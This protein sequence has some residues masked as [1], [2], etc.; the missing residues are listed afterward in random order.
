[1]A[2]EFKKSGI[3]VSDLG[4]V[5]LQHF[6]VDNILKPGAQKALLTQLADTVSMGG[7]SLTI[8]EVVRDQ[9]QVSQD[10]GELD[11]YPEAS[12]ELSAKEILAKDFGK[13]IKVT[14]EAQNVQHSALDVLSYAKDELVEELARDLEERCAAA[15][16]LAPLTGRFTSSTAIAYATN[17]AWAGAAANDANPYLIRKLAKDARQ[18]YNMP[19]KMANKYVYASTY[20][21]S[22]AIE[23]DPVIQNQIQSLGRD[24]LKPFYLGVLGDCIIMSSNMDRGI[25]DQI[26]SNLYPEWY[27]L[28]ARSHVKGIVRAPSVSVHIG[29]GPEFGY[30]KWS[31]VHYD[32]F[33]AFGITTDSVNKDQVRLIHGGGA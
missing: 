29:N 31:S 21:S 25:Q 33:M 1:M 23:S 15:L 5:S 19:T 8:P 10:V 2:V 22:F 24:E 32:A 6:F 11:A 3:P 20:T 18:L 9:T 7:V 16:A 13:T 27:L 12:L 26:G 30:G 4:N 28:G 17:G 14:R